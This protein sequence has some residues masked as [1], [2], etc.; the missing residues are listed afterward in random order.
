MANNDF[1][2]FWKDYVLPVA[3]EAAYFSAAPFSGG[4]SPVGQQ[5]WGG[6][7]GNVSNQYLGYLGQEARAGRDPEDTFLDYLEKYPW[8]ERYTA[9]GPGMRP[10]GRTSRF[11]PAT[12][13]VF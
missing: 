9:M 4:S 5:Y 8:T 13:Y 3:P 1:G 10:G 6:Q 7:Y 11:A 12:R 2:S